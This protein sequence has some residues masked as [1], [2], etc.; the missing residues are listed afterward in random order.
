MGKWFKQGKDGKAES[1][2]KDAVAKARAEARGPQRFWLKNDMDAKVT[3]LDTPAFFF[4]EHNLELQGKYF[5]FFTCI[6]DYDV[7]PPCED[8]KAPSWVVVGTVIDHSVYTK[9]DGTVIRDQKKLFVAKGQAR[10]N[11][12]KQIERRENDIKYSHYF[13]SRGSGKQECGTGENFDFEKKLTKANLEKY[14]KARWDKD[15]KKYTDK[16]VEE[17]LTPYNYEKLFAPKT[18]EELRKIV[19]G[20]PPVGSEEDDLKIGDAIDSSSSEVG[21][22]ELNSI[23]DLL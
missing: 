9:D 3:F 2:K 19:G 18:T 8:G 20:A 16:E 11:L 7:C 10:Q 12:L 1:Q 14:I 15:N 6:T 23:D 21:E 5:N 13:I 17:F 22:E 4:S